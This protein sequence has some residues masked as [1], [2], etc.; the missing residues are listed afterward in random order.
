M[1]IKWLVLETPAPEE[2]IV[3]AARLRYDAA[4]NGSVDIFCA[5]GNSEDMKVSVMKRLLS[6]VESVAYN[7]GLRCLMLEA[8][9]WRTD[10]DSLFTSC[11]YVENSGHIWPEEK[12]HL[13]TR[14][15]MVL[16]YLKTFPVSQPAHGQGQWNGQQGSGASEEAQ[17]KGA[18]AAGMLLPVVA[19]DEQQYGKPELAE[20][21]VAPEPSAP[22]SADLQLADLHLNSSGQAGQQHQQVETM[23]QLMDSL[24]A[25]LHA[26]YGDG[27][28]PK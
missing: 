24:F 16:Q 17:S 11:G 25:A 28:D 18:G 4:R 6:V 27:A 21:A 14:P 26:E 13:L 5:T 23:P 2:L 12:Q 8:A 9:Q 1:P 7:I 15:T 10:L 3:G 22:L 19:W 20:P